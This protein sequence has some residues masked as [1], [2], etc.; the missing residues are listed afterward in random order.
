MSILLKIWV[1]EGCSRS[2]EPGDA[3][4]LPVCKIQ[5]G[6]CHH[7][8]CGRFACR[9]SKSPGVDCSVPARVSAGIHGP[10]LELYPGAV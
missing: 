6:R 7:A 5:S 9:G 2:L 1:S 3:D 8:R 10:I 4:C